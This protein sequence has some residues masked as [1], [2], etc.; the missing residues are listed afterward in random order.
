MKT[1]TRYDDQWSSALDQV[2]NLIEN[3]PDDKLKKN[4]SPQ[5]LKIDEWVAVSIYEGGFSSVAWRPIFQN[6][7][8]IL[9]RFYKLPEYRFANN[10]RHVSQETL[11]MIK[12]QLEIGKKLDFDCGFM[13]RDGKFASFNHYK[14]YLPQTWHS[15][16]EKYKMWDTGFQHIMWTPLNTN[17]LNMEKE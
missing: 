14:K 11:E 5:G 1:F 7:C 3:M 4:Y 17:T 6:N 16:K 8:R 15:P 9:N 13:S 12:Q 2:F 10:K